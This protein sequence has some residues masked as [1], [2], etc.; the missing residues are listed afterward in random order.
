MHKEYTPD[1]IEEFVKAKKQ[2][3][4]AIK[5][6]WKLLGVLSLLLI[7]Y[8]ILLYTGLFDDDIKCGRISANVV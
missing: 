3:K 8:L 7:I 5:G 1:A 4:S 2:E 6:I